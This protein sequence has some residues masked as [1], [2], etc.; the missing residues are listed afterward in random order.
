MRALDRVDPRPAGVEEESGGHDEH[1][2]VDHAREPHGDHHVGAAEAQELALLGLVASLDARLGERGVQVDDVGPD[3]GAEDPDRE[4]HAVGAGEGRDEPGREPA[5]VDA[6]LHEVVQEAEQDEAEHGRD[7]QLEAPIPP[8]LER[9]DGEGHDRGHE[10][11]RE[12]GH[13]EEQ[14]EGDGRAHELGQVRGDGDGLGLDPEPEADR[15]GHRVATQL[16]QVAL[17]GDADLR[18]QVLHE[19]RVASLSVE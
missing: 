11:G 8:A 13:A 5:R 7:R 10:P 9:E 12:Q 2:H 14:V 19:A 3:R 16:R 6:A 17:R 15:P 4:Q 1:G 18:R